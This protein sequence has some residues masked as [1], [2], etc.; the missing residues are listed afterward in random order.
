M[1][2]NLYYEQKK[3]PLVRNLSKALNHIYTIQCS[4]PHIR[5]AGGAN[6]FSSHNQSLTLGIL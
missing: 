5:C 2:V 4:L 6:N 1:G 3:K